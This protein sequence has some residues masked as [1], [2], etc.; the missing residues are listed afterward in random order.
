MMDFDFMVFMIRHN[1]ASREINN[2]IDRK[3][4]GVNKAISMSKFAERFKAI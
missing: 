4:K 1:T 3:R 2:A